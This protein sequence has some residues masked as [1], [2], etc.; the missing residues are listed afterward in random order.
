MTL[1][2]RS[3]TTWAAVLLALLVP[4]V[5]HGTEF[6]NR[7]DQARGN[8]LSAPAGIF[9]HYCAHC[10]G[11]DGKGQGRLWSSEMSPKPTDLT[12]L[13]AD[14][15]TLANMIRDGTAAQGKSPLCPPWGRTISP[16][17]RMRLTRYILALDGGPPQPVSSAV[18]APAAREPFPWLSLLVIVAASIMLWQQRRGRAVG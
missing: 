2:A 5:G 3:S 9:R 13:E 15:A 16:Q 7:R 10:H 14:E 17:D 8:F 11:E 12:G 6:I 18:S 1:Q 4:A